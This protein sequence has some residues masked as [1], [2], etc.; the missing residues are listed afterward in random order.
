M[1]SDIFSD[2]EDMK[3]KPFYKLSIYEILIQ[4][5]KNWFDILDDIMKGDISIKTLTKTDRLFY[6]GL[7]IFIFALLLYFYDYIFADYDTKYGIT[8]GGDLVQIKQV[9]N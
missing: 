2:V 8:N 7:T 3:Y 1:D 5:K 9:F 4:L 6:I